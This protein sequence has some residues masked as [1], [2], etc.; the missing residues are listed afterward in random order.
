VRIK[1]KTD[2]KAQIQHEPDATGPSGVSQAQKHSKAS[3]GS[4][5][6]HR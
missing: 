6:W 1:V 3:R 5:V 4:V 2:P